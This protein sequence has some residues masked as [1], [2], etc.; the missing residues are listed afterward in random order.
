MSVLRLAL[1]I[2]DI[3]SEKVNAL[4]P[5]PAR[6]GTGGWKMVFQ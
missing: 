1:M 6:S 2:M 5:M 3:P 4:S